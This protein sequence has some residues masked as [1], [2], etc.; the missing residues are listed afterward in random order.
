MGPSS[1]VCLEEGC[2]SEVQQLAARSGLS[3][4]DG[5]ELAGAKPKHLRR[6]LDEQLG[7]DSYFVFLYDAEGLRLYA[8]GE[9]DLNIRAD[10]QS[11]SVTYRR[12]QGGGRGQ[13]I[14]RAVGFKANHAP[15]VLDG[16][17][18]LGGDAFVLASLGCEV[19]MCERVPAV[20]ALLADGL[21]QARKHADAQDAQLGVVL[22][23]MK[24]LEADA[25]EYLQAL[26]EGERPDVIY[27]DP[28]FPERT[29]SALVKK[30]MRVFHDLV[31]ADSD[32][33]QLL[34]VALP[35]ARQRVVVKRPR[36]ATAL[37]GPKP[38]NVIEGKT[39][40]YDI[41]KCNGP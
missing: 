34:E 3:V 37:S 36:L 13:L 39:S 38:S 23:R 12:K 15:R 24:L 10:F 19:R 14:A 1:I 30:E 25:I 32:A 17:A 35:V 33:D 9:L 11:P 2:L 26:D 16:T 8:A 40:R 29:K 6:F 41:Y 5:S 27:L 4:I 22:D 20:R 28:M 7:C 31:G 21:V 18:G